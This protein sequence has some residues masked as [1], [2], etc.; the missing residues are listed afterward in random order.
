MVLVAHRNAGGVE[1]HESGVQDVILSLMSSLSEA[2]TRRSRR[3][4][5]FFG[6]L[7]LLS[8]SLNIEP[9]SA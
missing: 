8:D 6:R 7:P 9:T 1:L 5:A 3:E 4:T 2:L